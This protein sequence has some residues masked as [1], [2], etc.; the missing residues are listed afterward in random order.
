MQLFWATSNNPLFS[1]SRV[2]TVN[3]PVANQWNELVFDL[4]EH[5][6]WKGQKIVALRFDTT[7]DSSKT[8]TT[9]VDHIFG[10]S[11]Y[12]FEF[13]GT[14]GWLT[15]GTSYAGDS[16]NG[17]FRIRVAPGDNDPQLYRK[18]LYMDGDLHKEVVV[19]YWNDKA[20]NVQLF[21]GVEGNAGFSS[22]RVKTVYAPARKWVYLSF[23]MSDSPWWNGK[24]I[25]SLRID[26]P[27]VS[28]SESTR[29]TYVDW[30]RTN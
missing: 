9:Y 17:W 12:S 22:D 11:G 23:N 2:A 18:Y 30:I 21:W 15:N 29:T 16:I 10:D 3:Y 4:S 13:N 14:N 8:T 20:G 7:S 25:V 26:P 19:R 6:G 24:K 1:Q 28:Y 27:A 5:A